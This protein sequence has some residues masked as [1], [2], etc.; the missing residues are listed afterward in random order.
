MFP[1]GIFFGFEDSIGMYKS[2]SP[3]KGTGARVKGFTTFEEEFRLSEIP[4]LLVLEFFLVRVLK[5]LL[6]RC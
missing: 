6:K 5:S 3:Y 1:F 2:S 4:C